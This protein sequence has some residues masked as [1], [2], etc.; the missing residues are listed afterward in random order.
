MGFLLATSLLLLEHFVLTLEGGSLLFKLRQPLLPI[1]RQL[2]L[3]L[4]L[5]ALCPC[6]CLLSPLQRLCLFLLELEFLVP[7]L[8]ELQFPL[9]QLVL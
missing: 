4:M 1:F 8:L 7:L 3:S 2:L 9:L 5:S 6:L